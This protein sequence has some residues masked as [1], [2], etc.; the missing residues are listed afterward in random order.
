MNLSDFVSSLSPSAFR[1]LMEA[2][3]LRMQNDLRNPLE[4]EQLLYSEQELCRLGKRIQAIKSVRGRLGLGLKEAK[5]LVDRLCPKQE[6][7][8]NYCWDA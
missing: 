8:P 4:G 7:D 1:A 5:E 2:C 6:Q 3:L